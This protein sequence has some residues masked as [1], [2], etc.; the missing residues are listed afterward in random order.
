M[1]GCVLKKYTKKKTLGGALATENANP[2]QNGPHLH[3]RTPAKVNT[4]NKV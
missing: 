2:L 1:A 3:A 4:D